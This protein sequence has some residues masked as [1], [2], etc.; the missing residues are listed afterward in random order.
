MTILLTRPDPLPRSPAGD[1]TRSDLTETRASDRLYRVTIIARRPTTQCWHD[2]CVGRGTVV[3]TR[4]TLEWL[5][6]GCPSTRLLPILVSGTAT[7]T[8]IIDCGAWWLEDDTVKY[9]VPN[10]HCIVPIRIPPVCLY[11]VMIFVLLPSPI[12]SFGF[13]YYF[14]SLSI[15]YA[16]FFVLRQEYCNKNICSTEWP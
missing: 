6:V 16:V 5:S 8:K 13:A 7:Q 11:S 15:L 3:A 12:T 14:S 9:F 10:P 1:P 2:W 4:R